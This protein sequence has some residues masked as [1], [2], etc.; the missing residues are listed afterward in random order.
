MMI[1]CRANVEDG[2]PPLNQHWIN[3]L[4]FLGGYLYKLYT[5]A[6]YKSVTWS[7]RIDL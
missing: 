1:Q 4:C 6:T 7:Y 3:V 2:G 5:F